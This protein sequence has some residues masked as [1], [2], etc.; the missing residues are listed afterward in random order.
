MIKNRKITNSF[1]KEVKKAL[2][3]CEMTQVELADMLGIK[4]Q[5]LWKILSGERAGTKYM[6]DIRKILG[7]NTA[8]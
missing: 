6:D 8:A 1:A 4:K 5:Y 7:L 3:E 2:I